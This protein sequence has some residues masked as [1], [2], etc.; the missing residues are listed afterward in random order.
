MQFARDF[1][2]RQPERGRWSTTGS[3]LLRRLRAMEP[4]AA[5]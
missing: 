2:A 5:A 3:D 4:G 1:A